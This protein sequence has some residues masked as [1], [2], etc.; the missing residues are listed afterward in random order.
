MENKYLQD[1]IYVIRTVERMSDQ[2]KSYKKEIL[3]LHE[4]ER[5]C[6]LSIGI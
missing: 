1:I 5:S 2:D 4:N 3:D 6:Y